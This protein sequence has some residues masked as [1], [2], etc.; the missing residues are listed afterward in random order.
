MTFFKIN[1][2]IVYVYKTVWSKIFRFIDEAATHTYAEFGTTKF[3]GR[4]VCMDIP[5]AILYVNSD[6]LNVL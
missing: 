2:H 6:V 1:S 3:L 4:T 5:E